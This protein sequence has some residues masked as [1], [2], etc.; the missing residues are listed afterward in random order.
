MTILA[1]FTHFLQFLLAKQSRFVIESTTKGS[2]GLGFDSG[3]I[4]PIKHDFGDKNGSFLLQ[5]QLNSRKPDGQ[6]R[7]PNRP[8]EKIS[9]INLI[10][11]TIFDSIPLDLFILMI[12]RSSGIIQLIFTRA[13]RIFFQSCQC[14][15]MF[16][17]V[18]D[19]IL[20]S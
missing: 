6:N 12:K 2:Y 14:L 3:T 17:F 8:V 11:M 13:L 19:R 16:E 1:I 15:R 5:N 7:G 9:L 18:K 4:Q 20:F 10:L